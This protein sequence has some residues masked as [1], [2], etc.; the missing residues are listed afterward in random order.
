MKER[1]TLNENDWTD[2]SVL[3][4]H[5]NSEF[6]KFFAASILGSLASL[7]EQRTKVYGL[8]FS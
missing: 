6:E 3:I 1:N 8:H 5:R 7:F 4:D 2:I